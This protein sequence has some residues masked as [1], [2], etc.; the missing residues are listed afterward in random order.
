MKAFTE[1]HQ[2]DNPI[3]RGDRKVKARGKDKC[4][5]E[6]L[7]DHASRDVKDKTS[8]I[9]KNGNAYWAQQFEK[10]ARRR[11]TRMGNK[12]HPEPPTMVAKMCREGGELWLSGLPTER[13]YSEFFEPHRFALQI[14]CFSGSPDARKSGGSNGILLPTALQVNID[15]D[16]QKTQGTAKDQL[17]EHIHLI[18]TFLLSGDNVLVHCGGRNP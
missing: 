2:R 3:P 6:T 11:Q 15:M 1:Q 8:T 12:N 13:T 18:T 17:L 4:E 14:C 7:G 9:Q 5:T 16:A 10:L